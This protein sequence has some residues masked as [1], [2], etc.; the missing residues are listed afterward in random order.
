M[1][2]GLAVGGKS[3]SKLS[4]RLAEL[5]TRGVLDVAGV[6]CQC[7]CAGLGVTLQ[8]SEK[9]KLF[10]GVLGIKPK[11]P[12]PPGVD[13]MEDGR[14][15]CLDGGVDGT[16]TIVFLPALAGVGDAARN[17]SKSAPSSPFRGVRDQ[18]TFAA[19]VLL[20]SRRCDG[21]VLGG[22]DCIC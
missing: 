2:L 8:K 4:L 14:G 3:A 20:T 17:M 10:E 5:A 12:E 15:V 13:I 21:G 7:P 22:D 16:C 6:F 1:T 11:R 9:L 19:L 18:E